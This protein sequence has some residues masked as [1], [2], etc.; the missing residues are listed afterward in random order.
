MILE[1]LDR[2][3]R[4]RVYAALVASARAPTAASLAQL[5][6]VK[7]NDVRAALERLH[8]AHALVLD[9]AT[10]EVRMALP[11]ANAPTAYRVETGDRA[12][13]ANC[14]WDALAMVRLLDLR[15]ARVLDWGG[16]GRDGR[17]LTVAEG[18]LVERDGVSPS[19]RPGTRVGSTRTTSARRS[20]TS[21]RCFG[22]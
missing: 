16:P 10:R 14:A 5:L 22:E 11:F 18:Q 12:W 6:S 13:D 3:V 21:S 4:H 2:A 17:V 7:R 20:S 19:A 1:V 8:D 9:A 15:Q